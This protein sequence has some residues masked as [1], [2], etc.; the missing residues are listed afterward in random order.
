M[1]ELEA[2]VDESDLWL[3]YGLIED[4]VRFTRSA[5]GRRVLDNWEHLVA[6]FVKV[7]P[8][9][10]RRV[11]QARRAASARRGADADARGGRPHLAV[12]GGS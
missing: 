4:H 8:T 5:L 1:V 2:V 9:D 11:L 12:V 10:Y 3:L 6:R 7:M